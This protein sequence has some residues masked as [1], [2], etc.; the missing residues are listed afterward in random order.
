MTQ[1]QLKWRKFR[2]L[3]VQVHPTSSI[4]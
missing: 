3:T 1:Y 2:A 4:Y